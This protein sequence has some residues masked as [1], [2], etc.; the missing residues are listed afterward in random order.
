[1]LALLLVLL[2]LLVLGLLLALLALLIALLLAL[3]GSIKDETSVG[4]P[5]G[6]QA[7]EAHV[8]EILPL[9]AVNYVGQLFTA[10]YDVAVITRLDAKQ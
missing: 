4:L 7:A 2:V 3:L 8:T 1:M 9:R 10:Q 6:T 5:R